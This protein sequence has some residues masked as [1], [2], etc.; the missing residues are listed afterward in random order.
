V[1]PYAPPAAPYPGPPPQPGPTGRAPLRFEISEVISGAWEVF[2]RQWLPLC[3][4]ILIVSLIVAVPMVVLYGVG[5]FV[6]LAGAGAASGS[7]PDLGAA[8]GIAMFGGM[9]MTMMLVMCLLMPLFLGRLLRMALTAVRGGTP[10]VGDL[11]TGEMRY[12]SMLALMLLQGMLIG[13]GYMLFIVP[14]VILAL[15]LYF[16]AYLVIDQRMGA[17][18]AMKASWQLTTGRKGEV[19]VVML[20]FGL[21]SA[22]CGLIPLVGHFIGYSLMMLGVSIVYLRLIG[23]WAPVVPQPQPQYAAQAG[24]YGGYPAPYG[25]Q[26]PYPQQAYGQQQYPQ[27]P[28]GQQAYGPPPPPAGGFGGYGPPYGGGSNGPPPAA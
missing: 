26:Q 4:A 22:V 19:F 8:V 5:M 12:G 9:F 20:V 23:E 3:V 14:G 28:Y 25:Q 27:Q 2:T 16:S 24:P 18:E 6:V 11:F 15:G 17:V 10:T 1:Q 13:L 7:D 21:L